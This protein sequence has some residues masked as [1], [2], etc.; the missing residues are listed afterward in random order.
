MQ[1]P[2]RR[3]E[4]QMDIHTYTHTHAPNPVYEQEDVTVLW[5]KAI[6]TDREVTTN[7]PDI[8]IK[9]KKEKT[10]VLIDVAMP[11]DRNVVQKEAEKKLKYKS[12]CSEIHE[13]YDY[14]GNNWSRRNSNKMFTE[15]FG[16]HTRKTRIDSP[17]KT[18]LL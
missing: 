14:I 13:V 17:Q 12:L 11:T 5:N 3:N 1:S 8:I 9:N 4:R 6:H 18:A 7:R 2:R 10:C 15:K 16:S